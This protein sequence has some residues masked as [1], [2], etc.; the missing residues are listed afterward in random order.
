MKQTVIPP[1]A[2]RLADCQTCNGHGATRI[3]IVREDGSRTRARHALCPDCRG[4]GGH[5]RTVAA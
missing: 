2:P 3:A 5:V 4:T 1:G